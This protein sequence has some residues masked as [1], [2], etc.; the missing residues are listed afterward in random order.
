MFIETKYYINILFSLQLS[1]RISTNSKTYLKH[2]RSY[3]L[4]SIVI[5]SRYYNLQYQYTINNINNNSINNTN[6]IGPMR[7]R[8]EIYQ[9]EKKHTNMNL[10]N[11]IYRK[12]KLQ[13]KETS[14]NKQTFINRKM[15][16]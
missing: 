16:Q 11:K 15:K 2:Y 1:C 14:K 6:S 13:E 5:V 3:N 7:M 9:T 10:N 4:L 8:M 12:Y